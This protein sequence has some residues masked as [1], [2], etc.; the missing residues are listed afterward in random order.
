MSDPTSRLSLDFRSLEGLKRDARAGDAGKT[1]DAA[2]AAAK[3]FESEFLN[4]LMKSMR[5]AL[6]QSDA[7]ASDS[8][9]NWQGMLDRHLTQS[10]SSKGIGLAELIEKQL[11]RQTSATQADA[12]KIG[13]AGAANAGDATAAG[14]PGV[15]P[16]NGA[17]NAMKISAP[18]SAANALPMSATRASGSVAAASAANGS[19]LERIL[20]STI[21][22]TPAR[23]LSGDGMAA[24]VNAAAVRD[25]VNT[26]RD[27]VAKVADDAKAASQETGIP[28]E[29]IVGQA[30][31]ESGWGKREIRGAD[32]TNSHNLFGIKAGNGWTGATVEVTT[33]EYVQG[34]ARKVKDTFRAYASYAEGFADYAKLLAGNTRY[35][36]T[37]QAS[38]G[39]QFGR[40]MQKAG[41]ATDPRYGEKLAGVIRTASQLIK[42]A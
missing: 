21:A 31:L 28:A 32:G 16:A 20:E 42:Q 12:A 30:A 24:K 29:F 23:V 1:R 14:A 5:D 2:K 18:A 26:P 19:T 17:P 34:V 4:L 41:Y 25:A 11:L 10:L 6:P 33:T 35:A 15:A 8:S 7:L 27:F 39:D 22:R 36:G 3:Q 37:L 38:S 13:A 40:A 9:R